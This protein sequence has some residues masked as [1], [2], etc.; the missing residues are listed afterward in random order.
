M[1]VVY[2]QTFD[3]V[4]YAKRLN[5]RSEDQKRRRMEDIGH[6]K[7][8][9]G[10]NEEFR[11][12]RQITRPVY[13]T[14]LTLWVRLVADRATR[15]GPGLIPLDVRNTVAEAERRLGMIVTDFGEDLG[16]TYL[17]KSS[18]PHAVTVPE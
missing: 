11:I 12:Q 14:Y 1:S 17:D 6:L 10:E 16:V 9:F 2:E 8:V 18:P 3:G 4:P 5:F 13:D 15:W 7:H